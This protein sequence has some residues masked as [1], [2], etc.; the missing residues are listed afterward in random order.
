M[1]KNLPTTP[2]ALIG[3]TWPEIEPHYKDLESRPLNAASVDAWLA[4]WTSVGE[5]LDEMY[6]RLSVATTVNTVDKT[7]EERMNQFLDG[8][9][10]N[11][12]AADQKLKEKLL[13]SK[14]EPKGFEIPLRNMRAEADL[15][16]EANLSLLAEQQ[17]LCIEYDK[18]IGAQT[19]QWDGEEVTLTR[20]NLVFQ[21]TDRALREK[22]WRDRKSVV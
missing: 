1:L 13:A 6:A 17:K 16:R 4:D 8:V 20:L 15:F 22:A 12:M 5:R 3:W 2:E 7:A 14:L 9:F 18:I 19:I 11:V 10:P 21:Q